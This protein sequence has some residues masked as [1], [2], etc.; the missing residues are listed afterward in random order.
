MTEGRRRSYC[1]SKDWSGGAATVC[2]A[3]LAMVIITS[4][5][6]RRAGAVIFCDMLQGGIFVDDTRMDTR[7]WIFSPRGGNANKATYS[8]AR[9]QPSAS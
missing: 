8:V 6:R 9:I 2:L 5:G 7:G 3:R 4:A 1:M